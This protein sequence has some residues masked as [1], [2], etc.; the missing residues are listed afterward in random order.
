VRLIIATNAAGTDSRN[1]L[2]AFLEAKKWSIWHW[3][4]D[5]WLVDGVPEMARFGQLRDEILKAIPTL[6]QVLIL[7]TEARITH[8][9]TVPDGSGEWF[10]EHWNQ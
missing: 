4:Q 2:T 9:G 3:Y 1:A 6:R 7:T 10:K 8:S 5:L